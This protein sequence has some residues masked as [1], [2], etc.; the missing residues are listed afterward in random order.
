[1]LCH[2]IIVHVISSHRY[3]RKRQ[4]YYEI[5]EGPF[6]VTGQEVRRSVSAH[7][8]HQTHSYPGTGRMNYEK[9]L[10]G[11]T[12][13]GL[14]TCC[15]CALS[16]WRE[17]LFPVDLFVKPKVKDAAESEGPAASDAPNVKDTVEKEQPA[18][19]DASENLS[20]DGADDHSNAAFSDEEDH[21]ENV[22]TR[23]PT[24]D[25]LRSAVEKEANMKKDSL[26]AEA[27]LQRKRSIL[28]SI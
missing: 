12:R 17:D 6:P 2:L 13:R 28:G 21:V 11:G 10:S 19:S 7:A 25:G 26:E 16:H 15:V 18:A 8:R 5:H 24:L 9:D 14:G 4:L 20:D 23:N 3:A 27:E 22:S 1:M